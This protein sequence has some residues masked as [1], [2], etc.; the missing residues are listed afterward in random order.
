MNMLLY[1]TIRMSAKTFRCLRKTHIALCTPTNTGETYLIPD[2]SLRAVVGHLS[3]GLR[4]RTGWPVAGIEYTAG[5]AL[6][7]GPAGSVLRCRYAV[8][9]VSLRML[10]LNV[11]CFSPPLPRATALAVQRLRMSN[12]IKVC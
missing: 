9:T 5:G 7:R 10:Q 6:L 4:I 11:P 2:R 1:V 3:K 12:A 8:V